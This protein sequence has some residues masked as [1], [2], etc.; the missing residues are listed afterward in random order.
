[1]FIN[2]YYQNNGCTSRFILNDIFN[3]GIFIEKLMFQVHDFACVFFKPWKKSLQTIM[4]KQKAMRLQDQL[5][6]WKFKW[7]K[8]ILMNIIWFLNLN[9]T[10]EQN[11]DEWQI[12]AFDIIFVL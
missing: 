4:A 10:K 9:L 5:Y 7:M 11:K 1:M 8:W 6:K 12:K 2:A 3:Y